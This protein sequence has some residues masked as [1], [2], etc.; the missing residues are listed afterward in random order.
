MLRQIDARD[1]AALTRL[2]EAAV[3]WTGHSR[4]VDAAAW[5]SGLSGARQH[6]WAAQEGDGLRCAARLQLADRARQR[7]CAEIELLAAPDDGA[8][9]MLEAIVR[10]A[11]AW[12]AADRVDL[13]LPDGHAALA[14]A[15]D[16]GFLP[17]VRRRARLTDGRDELGLARLRPGFLPR[18]PGGPPPWPPRHRRIVGAWTL[19]PLVAD[20]AEAVRALSVEPTSVWGTLQTPT[21]NLDFYTQRHRDT[22][23]GHAL[24]ALE[25]DGAFAGIGG[26]HPTPLDEVVVVGMALGVDWQGCGG[27]RALMSGL[28]RAARDRGA[29]RVELAVWA[30][31]ARARALYA[32]SGF[33]EEGVRRGD[34]IRDG[35]HGDSLEMALD[36]T[37]TAI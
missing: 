11:D 22:P 23:P 9:A 24:F 35:G 12:T 20:D 36:L 30:D 27:G 1:A 2:A 14:S 4:P 17:E 33:V 6:L 32:A 8:G 29:R 37:E 26:I 13:W 21:S 15:V 3:A 34:G 19:R 16:L 25:A 5:L 31:N 28:L 7:H 10:F 18:A